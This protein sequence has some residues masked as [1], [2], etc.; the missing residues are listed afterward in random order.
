MS[1]YKNT[2]TGFEIET[3]SKLSGDWEIVKETVK[4]KKAEAKQPHDRR[5]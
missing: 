2:K 3:T 5:L 1:V 4:K